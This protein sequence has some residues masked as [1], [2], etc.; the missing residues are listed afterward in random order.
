MYGRSG[1]SSLYCLVTGLVEQPN[2]GS[3]IGW[4]TNR[5]FDDRSEIWDFRGNLDSNFRSR[6][7]TVSCQP[8]LKGL[9]PV[10]Y[11]P[12]STRKS[13]LQTPKRL[14]RLMGVVKRACR[15]LR[16]NENKIPGFQF[17]LIENRI[18]EVYREPTSDPDSDVMSF[19]RW[20]N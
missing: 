10:L 9:C 12:Y 13:M 7:C 3:Q 1:G 20:W 11:S 2:R 8:E 19:A 16:N 17:F 15:M 14:L 18:F 5:D 4:I 6:W